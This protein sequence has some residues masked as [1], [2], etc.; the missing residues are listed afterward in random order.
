[1]GPLNDQPAAPP[2]S[3]PASPSLTPPPT[4][5]GDLPSAPPMP[6]PAPASTG[7]IKPEVTQAAGGSKKPVMIAIIIVL[8]I[9]ILG[10]GGFFIFNIM[11]K[12]ADEEPA[13]T[14]ETAGSSNQDIENLNTE[15]KQ[16]EITDPEADLMEVDQQINTID[17]SA[18][19]SAAVKPAA[20]AK[21]SPTIDR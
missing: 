5:P 19:P 11:I 13:E 18:S 3:S 17:A 4:S 12:P 20:S 21:A 2:P 10:I 16:I 1:M 14:E 6:P 7:A 8:I 15:V 9:A